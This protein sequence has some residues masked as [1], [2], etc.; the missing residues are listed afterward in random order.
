MVD[1]AA[2]I[3]DGGACRTIQR[4]CMNEC[5]PH[6]GSHI[7]PIGFL[8]TACVKEAVFTHSDYDLHACQ[9]NG[10][11]ISKRLGLLSAFQFS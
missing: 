8:A 9:Q 5:N 3:M 11:A 2:S 1:H 6:L 7:K 10:Q 4:Y